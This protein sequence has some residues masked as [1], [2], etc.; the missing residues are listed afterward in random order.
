MISQVT[1]IAKNE[2]CTSLQPKRYLINTDDKHLALS[3]GYQ[4]L[5]KE[6]H[7]DLYKALPVKFLDV[8]DV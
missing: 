3:K 4:L 2:K 6:K 5:M 1:F 7:C 8:H